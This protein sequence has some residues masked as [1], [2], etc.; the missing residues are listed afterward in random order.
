MYPHTK[1]WP[2][3]LLCIIPAS[4]FTSP[5]VLHYIGIQQPEIYHC[6][7]VGNQFNL[8]FQNLHMNRNVPGDTLFPRAHTKWVLQL[9]VPCHRNSRMW[10]AATHISHSL[11]LDVPLNLGCGSGAEKLPAWCKHLKLKQGGRAGLP[12]SHA[13]IEPWLQAGGRCSE[14]VSNCTPLVL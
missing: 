9:S 4:S 14:W 10:P 13:W 6:P 5:G 7:K 2:W 12:A 11:I 1:Y 8:C 3:I